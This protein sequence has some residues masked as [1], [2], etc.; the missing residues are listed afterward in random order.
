M[1]VLMMGFRQGMAKA[2]E[3]REIPYIIWSENPLKNPRKCLHEI[4]ATFP[5]ATE[6]IASKRELLVGITHIIATTESAVIPASLVRRALGLFR[7]PETVITRCT[8]KYKMKKFLREKEIPMTKFLSGKKLT[9]KEIVDELGLPLVNKVKL[10]SGGRGV[11]FISNLEDIEKFQSRDSYFESAIKGREG[12]IES[13]VVDRKVVFTNIT[14]Y[15]KNGACN[16]LPGQYEEETKDEI[17]KLNAS[18][19]KAINLKWGMTHL[20]YYI[21]EKGILFGE[22]ALR[23]PGGYIMEALSSSY[24]QNFWD[25]FLDVELLKKAI[26]INPQQKYSSS[27]IIHPG[28]GRIEELKGLD[29]VQS[30]ESLVK[31]K[32]KVKPGDILKK[33][34]GV[35]EDCGYLILANE[36]SEKLIADIETFYAKL[37]LEISPN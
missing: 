26:T 8:D 4:I 16:I 36:S 37:K 1:I 25:V 24:G 28:E 17:Q 20:E 9:P 13:F 32:L 15:Y 30:L 22:V 34:E 19:L 12:S 14:Q 11:E 33:R 27:I 2:L 5:S 31:F 18:V 35:G 10:S 29:E 21:T 7:N 3:E 6:D 23:P